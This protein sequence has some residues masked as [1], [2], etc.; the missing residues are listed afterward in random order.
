MSVALA[1]KHNGK[2]DCDGAFRL[3][4]CHWSIRCEDLS[5]NSSLPPA[6]CCHDHSHAQKKEREG[7]CLIKCP[8]TRI[9]IVLKTESFFF[10]FKAF[11]H[12]KCRFSKNGLQSGVFLANAGLLETLVSVRNRTA[13]RRGRQNVC[14]WQ[15]WQ[16]YYLRVLSWSPLNILCFL[17]FCKKISLK[18]SEAWR[19]VIS[20]QNYCHV[21][22]TRF[23]VFLPLPSCCVSSLLRYE[24]GD[25][26]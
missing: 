25:G 6:A 21:C 2:W 12:Q 5:A 23:A 13:G 3:P 1:G 10:P 19:K 9:L 8:S 11:R 4:V 7:T 18:E 14:V 15:T 16:G 24:D 22:L 20:K 26:R 17:V